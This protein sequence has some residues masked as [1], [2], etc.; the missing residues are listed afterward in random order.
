VS[1]T[2][3]EL[4]RATALR[5][6]YQPSEM[7]RSLRT[8]LTRTIG[9]VVPDISS[10]FYANALKGAQH[11]LEA[12]GYRV[13]LADT[14][15]RPERE[16]DA[17]RSLMAGRVDGV[18]L[19]AAG[20]DG[21]KLRTLAARTSTPLVFFDNVVEGLGDGRVLMAN[22]AGVRLLVAHLAQVHGH[23]RIGY[24]GGLVRETSGSERLEGFRLA[25]LANGL[26]IDDRCIRHGDWTHV[27]GQVETAA[28]VGLRPRPTAIVYADADMTM[29]GL[30]MLREAGVGVPGEMAIVSF[31]DPA[32]GALLDP[33]VTALLRRDREIGDMAA[34]LVL[35]ALEQPGSSPP[36]VRI[37][38]ELS[39]RRS[40]GCGVEPQ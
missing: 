26:P 16:L 5:L 34:S 39:V 8:R 18:I 20:S 3:R 1:S 14:D 25:M 2:T 11:R 28:L 23:R 35:R 17:L 7:G 10:L 31:D 9:F 22:E 38:V 32:G 40:C 30:R 21:A 15:E 4:V 33:P 24:V 27:S 12:A 36:E 29:G 13:I 6:E 19:C 37:P